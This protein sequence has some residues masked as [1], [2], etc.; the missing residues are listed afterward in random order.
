MDRPGCLKVGGAARLL[1]GLSRGAARG[2]VPE[3]N[4]EKYDSGNGPKVKDRL[5]SNTRILTQT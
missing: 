2:Y 3:H 4:W 1:T 5:V